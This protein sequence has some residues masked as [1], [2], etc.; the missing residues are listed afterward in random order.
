MLRPGLPKL[1]ADIRAAR[2]RGAAIP[3]R[4]LGEAWELGPLAV[5][6]ASAASSYVTGEA[7]VI[8]GGAMAG[9]LTPGDWDL[10]AA[11]SAAAF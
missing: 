3:A 5:Y 10:T 8:D 9:G 4:R 1:E 2:S 6:L 7:F 11:G